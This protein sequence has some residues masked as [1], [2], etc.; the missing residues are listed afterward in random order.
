M[1]KTV[2]NLIW[3][4]VYP[5][6]PSGIDNPMINP[7]VLGSPSLA[8]LWFSW[9]LVTVAK[10]DVIRGLGVAYYDAVKKSS[11]EGEVELL[12]VDGEDHAFH[13]LHF[14]NQSAKDLIKHLASFLK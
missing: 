12:Q 7:T 14:D 3:N 1:D 8:R 4:L 11:C 5:S 9:L 2:D 13:F 10:I 6:I